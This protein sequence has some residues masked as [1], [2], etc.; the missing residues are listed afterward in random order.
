MPPKIQRFGPTFAKWFDK[1]CNQHIAKVSK[2]L[3]EALNNS[4][5]ATSYHL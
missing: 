1:V 4:R 3:I 2:G 5:V